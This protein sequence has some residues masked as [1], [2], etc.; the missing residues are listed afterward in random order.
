MSVPQ[1][2]H[3]T[4]AQTATARDIMTVLARIQLSQA[5]RGKVAIS[6]VYGGV[7][8][9]EEISPESLQQLKAHPA[10]LVS[11]I[12]YREEREK[13]STH[14]RSPTGGRK[15]FGDVGGRLFHKPTQTNKLQAVDV[16]LASM[17]R[18]VEVPA[19]I[20]KVVNDGQLGKTIARH[21]QN[22]NLFKDNTKPATHI[23]LSFRQAP[24]G[25]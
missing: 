1:T 20:V 25:F 8:S 22:E 11:L 2:Q 3:L 21:F 15:L 23:A 5:M 9:A 17:A 16:L 19:S 24:G 18:G 10:L 14:S 4:E 12:E 13:G 7:T 6:M